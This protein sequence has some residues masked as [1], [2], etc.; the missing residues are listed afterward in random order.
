MALGRRWKVALVVAPAVLLVG[1][2]LFW[3]QLTRP[4]L[5]PAE[6]G[7][8]IAEREGCFTCHGPEGTRGAPNPGRPLPLVPNFEGDVMMYA[9]SDEQLRQWIR[10]GVSEAKSESQSWRRERD[11]GL[12]V[13]P[14]FGDRLSDEEIDDLVAFVNAMAGP[15]APE[16]SLAGHGMERAEALGCFGCHGPGGRLSRPNPGSLKGYIPSWDGEDFPE[17]V[18]DRAEFDQWV[19]QGVSD[20]FQN[21]PI[22]RTFV[23]RASVH[24][25]GFEEFLEPGDLDALWAY[26]RWLRSAPR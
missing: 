7:R 16:D 3:E 11:R 24:M 9:R 10:D 25:P 26:V 23:D 4:R 8:R 5:P 14:A 13:M 21:D 12:L 1:A 15:P 19:L 22:A 18:A 20:R 2:L 6:R 17:L